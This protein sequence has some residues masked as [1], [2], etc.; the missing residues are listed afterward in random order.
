VDLIDRIRSVLHLLADLLVWPVFVGLIALAA[1][2]LIAAGSAAREFYERRQDNRSRMDVAA[3]SSLR[4]ARSADDPPLEVMAALQRAERR[5]WTAV[6]RVRL[7]V[8]LGPALGLMGPL[9]P[10]A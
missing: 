2:V 3:L 7:L 8:R 4:R 1:I 6:A 5:A 9:I 10:M